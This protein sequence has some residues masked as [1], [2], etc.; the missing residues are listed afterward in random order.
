MTPRCERGRLGRSEILFVIRSVRCLL[1][2]LV[3]AAAL[4]ACGTDG[5]PRYAAVPAPDPEAMYGSCAFCHRDVAVQLISTGFHGDPNLA[6]EFCHADLTPGHVGPGHR[7]VPACADCHSSQRTHHDPAAGTGMEC[8]V[9]HT[10]HGSP[11]LFLVKQQITTPTGDMPQI[12]F[13]NLRG[14]AD[15]SFASASNPGTGLCEVCHTQTKFYRSDGS[16]DQHF[17]FPCFT[18]HQHDNAFSPD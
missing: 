11:N 2:L 18:C 6:C 9:C 16:G 8:Q 5:A 3:L 17:P 10:P 12:R 7:N 14:R 4:A 13:T 1:L 15:G